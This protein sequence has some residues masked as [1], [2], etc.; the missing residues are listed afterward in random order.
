MT[1]DSPLILNTSNLIFSL[2]NNWM[3]L[4]KSQMYCK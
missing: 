4:K 3:H 1:S 2:K